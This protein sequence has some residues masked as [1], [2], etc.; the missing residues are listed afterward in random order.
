MIDFRDLALWGS[1]PEV[2]EVLLAMARKYRD[3]GNWR[4]A[5]KTYKL[6]RDSDKSEWWAIVF[7]D[8]CEI[9]KTPS[10]R[11]ILVEYAAAERAKRS[12]DTTHTE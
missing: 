7:S 3:A 10:A 4:D 5:F 8:V 1:A 2:E 6:I 9:M 11:S 12:S